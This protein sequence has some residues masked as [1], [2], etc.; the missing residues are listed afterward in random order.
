MSSFGLIHYNAPGNTFEEF[1]AFAASAGFG[2]IEV[3]ISDVWPRDTDFA[4]DRAYEAKAL[5]DRY[6][7]KASALTAANDFIQLDAKAI[8]VQ[9]E[10]MQKVAQLAKLLDT[11]ILRTEGGQPKESVP[12]EKWAGAIAGCLKACLPFCEDMGVRMAVDNHGLVSNDPAVLLPAL[13]MVS[14]PYAGSN[15]DTMN[16]RWWGN[17]V[18]DLPRIYHDL[19]P[20][21]LHT[22]MKDGSGARGD[23]KGAVLGEGEIPLKVAVQE[24][25]AAG[26]QGAWTAEWEGK[27]DKAEGYGACLAWLKANC[28]A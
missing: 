15:L 11:D 9:V 24:L 7:I 2:S 18:A 27:G 8:A 1:V 22:H 25:V 26:Y 20:Y 17:A 23:Y 16:L 19:A 10:R 28:P 6:G 4:P 14:S 5:L 12:K 3:M 13:E 21:V